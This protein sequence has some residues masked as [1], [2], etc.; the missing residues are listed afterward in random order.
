INSNNTINKA[1]L[2][3]STLKNEEYKKLLQSENSNFVMIHIDEVEEKLNN[4]S[5]LKIQKKEIRESLNKI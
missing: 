2:D 4:K 1:I 3:I 5:I